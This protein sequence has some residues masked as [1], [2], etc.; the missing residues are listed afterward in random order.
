MHTF[1]TLFLSG[2]GIQKVSGDG[3]ISLEILY[4]NGNLKTKELFRTV[5]FVIVSH[6]VIESIIRLFGSMQ[7]ATIFICRFLK[8]R[9]NLVKRGIIYYRAISFFL[10]RIR[11]VGSS[12][13]VVA[14][15]ILFSL[16]SNEKLLPFVKKL[17]ME[18]MKMD[19]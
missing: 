13:T 5:F 19:T 15:E 1:C 12:L 4:G 18:R 2:A 6:H 14:I 7:T 16:L 9:L 3:A 10:P 17:T 11:F 8:Y